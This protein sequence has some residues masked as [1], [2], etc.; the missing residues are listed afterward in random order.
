MCRVTR[1]PCEF[2]SGGIWRG[3]L[4]LVYCAAETAAK[5]SYLR[6][7]FFVYSFAVFFRERSV[8]ISVSLAQTGAGVTLFSFWLAALDY[9]DLLTTGVLLH[10]SNEKEKAKMRHVFIFET[11]RVQRSI[12]CHTVP[13][14]AIHV[15]QTKSKPRL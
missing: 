3:D 13:P 5:P 4:D 8:A 14:C 9:G 6:L 12:A 11:V 2:A 1:N 10:R 15:E 7:N